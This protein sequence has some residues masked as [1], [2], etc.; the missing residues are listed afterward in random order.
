MTDLLVVKAKIKDVAGQIN[1][2][3]DL[4]EALDKKAK[5]LL[6]DAVT[7]AK[8]NKRSTVMPKDIPYFF[9]CGTAKEMLVVRSKLKENCGDCN[10][11]GDLA[12]GLNNVL[13]HFVKEGIQRAADN[14]RST[15]MPKDL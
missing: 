11:A 7:R 2:A 6:K 10:V 9:C 15:I 1:V 3:G 4:A 5:E 14:K 13:N 12:E 8:E